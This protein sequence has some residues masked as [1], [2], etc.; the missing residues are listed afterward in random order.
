MTTKL[1]IRQSDTNILQDQLNSTA[2]TEMDSTLASINNEL[3]AP[4]R[5][6]ANTTLVITVGSGKV[7]NPNT[8]KNRVLPPVNNVVVN[9]TG[10]TVTFPSSA[11]GGTITNSNGSNATIT[12]GANQF[13]AVLFQV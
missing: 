5:I 13:A 10:A 2:V 3:T 11:T 8:S 12:I 9:F 6:F 7:I 4:G 1:D